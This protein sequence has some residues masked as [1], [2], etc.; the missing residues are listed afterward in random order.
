[1]DQS[2]Q[3]TFCGESFVLK[4]DQLYVNFSTVNFVFFGGGWGG[5]VFYSKLVLVS[6]AHTVPSWGYNYT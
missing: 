6:L 1:M 2:L 3:L 5:V 4:F